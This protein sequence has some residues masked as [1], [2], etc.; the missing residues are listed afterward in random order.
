M[1]ARTLRIVVT[2]A[3]GFIGRRRAAAARYRSFDVVALVREGGALPLTL[4]LA[5][6]LVI[7]LR[8]VTFVDRPQVIA[9]WTAI[10]V[11]G[12][13]LLLAGPLTERPVLVMIVAVVGVAVLVVAGGPRWAD[14]GRRNVVRRV[15]DLAERVTVPVVWVLVLAV[16]IEAS[17]GRA[18]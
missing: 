15:A 1:E 10:V 7:G 9:L 2:G 12:L 14:P 11:P 17:S 5:E 13:V 18:A 16:V 4:A 3:S 8:A 6:L